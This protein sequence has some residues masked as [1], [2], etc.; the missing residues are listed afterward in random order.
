M[1]LK[2]NTLYFQLE[3]LLLLRYIER[4]AGDILIMPIADLCSAYVLLFSLNIVF[5]V[6]LSPRRRCR[7]S[8]CTGNVLMA[9]MGNEI[10]LNCATL[11]QT[12]V[13]PALVTSIVF[14]NC[15]D[16]T[17]DSSM[18]WTDV[19]QNVRQ[20]LKKNSK[21]NLLYTMRLSLHLVCTS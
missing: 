5:T 18:E 8:D 12:F 11:T 15:M 16:H 4:V 9:V 19:S 14:S 10:Q 6:V 13:I 17:Y 20:L 2:S 1:N 7:S 3:N 21:S